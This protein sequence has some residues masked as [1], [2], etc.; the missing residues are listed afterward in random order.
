M[1]LALPLIALGG[2]FVVS[3]QSKKKEVMVEG[4][5]TKLK[6]TAQ[7]VRIINP[8]VNPKMYTDLA[9]RLVNSDTYSSSMTP[10]IGKSKQS[11]SNQ[12]EPILDSYTGAGTFHASK[13]EVAPLFKPEDNVQYA[14]GVP[15][16]SDFYHSR[17]NPSTRI[18]GMKP[19]Q[20]KEVGPGIG[21][22]FTS[23]GNGGFNSGVEARDAW[24][25]KNVDEMRV[26]T[27]PKETFELKG[28]QGPAQTL[29]KNLGK[30]GVVEKHLPDTFYIN[31][32]DRYLTT[33]GEEKGQ[34]SHAIQPDRTVHR[35]TTTRPYTGVAG[36][37]GVE[38]QSKPGMYRLDHRQQL[39]AVGFTPATG[40]SRN[41]EKNTHSLLPT[42]RSSN[43]QESFGGGLKGIVNAIT[44]PL[45]DLV[46]PTRKEDLV[47]LTRIGNM[48]ST[49][50]NAPAA[51]MTVPHTIKEGTMY[52]PYSIGQ[53]PSDTSHGQGYTTT[54]HQPIKN[55]RDT[56]SVQY[57]GGGMST[58]PHQPNYSGEIN[59]AEDRSAVGRIPSGNAQTYSPMINQVST[60]NRSSMHTSYMGPSIG[61]SSIPNAS[62]YGNGRSPIE[63]VEPNRNESSLL[64]AF[65]KNPY[66]QS[67]QSI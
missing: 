19:F 59:V 32:P 10:Y 31:T 51:K 33:T 7:D 47:G 37:S 13:T 62:Q 34:T 49:I 15:N 56:T 58:L 35:E 39:K 2:L 64:D 48:T 8:V 28:H 16:Q 27:N 55:Q 66:T 18:H 46:K 50:P 5:N 4:F 41:K 53:R 42:N 63:Y 65:K 40:I 12:A 52:S 22:G 38:N 20:E 36:N 60:T 24:T 1:E 57:M 54:E 29:V 26:A 61:K 25:D 45:I 17:V 67:L 30:E 9:G 21:K 11:G 3:N 23:G 6:P 14:H 44:A 43:Q